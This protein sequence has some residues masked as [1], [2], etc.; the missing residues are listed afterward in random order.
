MDYKS[1]ASF[2]F[3]AETRPGEF[4]RF[5]EQLL[6]RF[7]ARYRDRG[8]RVVVIG[9]SLIYH[10]PEEY[11]T[12]RTKILYPKIARLTGMT[13]GS[14]ES[15]IR[16]MARRFWNKDPEQLSAIAGQPLSKCPSS[17]EFLDLLIHF[18]DMQ[19]PSAAN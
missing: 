7:G 17:A 12:M 14:V 3:R 4:E 1:I 2:H 5:I 6:Y 10:D 8:Y 9:A 15:N 13:P 11:L 16:R 19:E 18:W